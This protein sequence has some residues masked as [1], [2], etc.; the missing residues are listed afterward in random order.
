LPF[1]LAVIPT[2]DLDTGR[3]IADP[4]EGVF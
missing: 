1:T 4:P 3:I 2:V